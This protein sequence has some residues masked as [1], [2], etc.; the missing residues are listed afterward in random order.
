MEVTRPEFR[1][2]PALTRE[3]MESLQ[4]E[5]AAEA[6][7]GDDVSL[8]DSP[9]VVGVDQAFP[10]ERAVS[11][12]VA[13]RDGEVVERVSSVT[14]LSIPYI[15]GLL[16]FR[17]GESILAA[18]EKLECEPDL[19]LFDGSGRIHFRQAGLATHMGVTLE[20]PSVGVAKS[21]LCGRLSNP[22]EDPF[23][24]GTRVPVVADGRV[25]VPEGT[26]LG[27]AVQTRQYEGGSRYINPL[28]VSPGHR[29][30]AETAAS[31]AESHCAGYKLPEPIRLADRYAGERAREIDA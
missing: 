27:Y 30:S 26:V 1:P 15:P 16:S 11:V 4:R 25:D 14:E 24:E 8:P 2:D 23:S 3:E 29:V 5:L 19:A 22:P 10:E 28:Y 18:F 17:E 21:L 13:M 7:F 6:C 20:L 9:V 12:V 31:L